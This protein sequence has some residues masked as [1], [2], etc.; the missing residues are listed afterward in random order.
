MTNDPV[1]NAYM[2]LF[3]RAGN[4]VGAQS[5]LRGQYANALLAPIQRQ[6]DSQMANDEF[7]RRMQQQQ[8]GLN[9]RRQAMQEGLAGALQRNFGAQPNFFA[10]P[11]YQRPAQT[12][13]ISA[14]I[15]GPVNA[16]PM[17]YRPN[18]M[19]MGGDIRNYLLR[20]LRG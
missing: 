2:A 18:D 17:G 4:D 9:E 15:G 12:P 3:A 7:N 10:S 20:Y 6:F 1:N 13:G 5:V 11:D 19:G 16:Q 14:G 8:F